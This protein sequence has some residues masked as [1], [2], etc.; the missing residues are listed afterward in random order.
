MDIAE[1]TRRA[2]RAIDGRHPEHTFPINDG[3]QRATPYLLLALVQEQQHLASQ[4]ADVNATLD[5]IAAAL[6]RHP[7]AAAASEVEPKR[8]LWLPTRR[9]TGE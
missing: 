2:E 1:L 8:R 6:E 3:G 7:E 4:L 9:R 5:R